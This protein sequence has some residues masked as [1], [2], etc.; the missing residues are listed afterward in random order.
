M[1]RF[2]FRL[3]SQL[4]FAAF[5]VSCSSESPFKVAGEVSNLSSSSH[6][7][8]KNSSD[9]PDQSGNSNE[10]GVGENDGSTQLPAIGG[11]IPELELWKTRMLDGKKYCV[12]SQIR[13]AI[14][15]SGVSNEGNVWFY[16]GA[17]VYFQIAEYTGDNSW[18]ECARWAA[19]A[20]RDWVL[21]TT[22]GV[23]YPVGRLS[24]WRIFP[25]GMYTNWQLRGDAS[26]KEAIK[27]MALYSAFAPLTVGDKC[28]Y[29]REIAYIIQAYIAYEKAG[30]GR[31][32]N[33]EKA[34][35]FALGHLDTVLDKQT[36]SW[37]APYMLGL[38]FAALI[39]YIELT[40]STSA[41][42]ALEKA[43][44][45]LWKAAW[46]EKDLSFFYDVKSKSAGEPDLNL[47]IAPAYAWLWKHTGNAVYLE[48]G[49][50]I[51]AGG[52]KGA[53]FWSGKQF[54][55]N[56][57]WSFDYVKWRSN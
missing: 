35:G 45:Q 31:H 19:E 12:E 51:F 24:G 14:G 33:L 32:P 28:Q 1:I 27:R 54:S 37:W 7:P 56:Y 16:D 38:N 43:T 21:S 4:A 5:V 30:F 17:R 42:A 57:R 22:N 10:I 18:L 40:N 53:E 6:D 29:V 8:G 25:H 52:V 9:N 13:G 39:E 3:L 47:L 49:D 55:Q 50:K 36:C 23:T 34:V 48:R 46:I 2:I 41:I 15:S 44:D 26:S 11:P 20:Y